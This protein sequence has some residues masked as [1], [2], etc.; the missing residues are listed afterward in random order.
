[1]LFQRRILMKAKDLIDKAVVKSPALFIPVGVVNWR[2]PTGSI[3]IDKILGGGFPGGRLTQIYGQEK[4]GKTTLL[5][6]AI[7]EGQKMGLTSVLLSLEGTY[8]KYYAKACGIDVDSNT[9]N[10][11]SSDNAE[12]GFNTIISLLM[13]SDAKIIAIDSIAA[14][15]PRANVEKKHAEKP[16][17]P[18]AVIGARSRVITDFITNA[19][20]P[21][22]R[23]DITL[24]VANQLR[25]KINTMG[26]RSPL[27]PAGGQALQYFT[28]VKVNMWKPNRSGTTTEVVVDKGKDWF[29][30]AYQACTIDIVHGK[31]INKEKEMIYLGVEAGLIKQAGSWFSYNN[32]KWHGAEDAAEVLC[33]DTAI[34]DE[35][36]NSIYESGVGIKPVTKELF[37]IMENKEENEGDA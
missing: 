28:T 36:R 11:F 5:Y 30:D 27:V 24:I 21:M 4:V 7:A 17:D 26:G 29:I 13:D 23:Q 12:A 10:V 20:I 1:M 32:Y 14:A 37:Q 18:G 33:T 9:F 2:L 16:S 19:L 25:T 31:G 35:L 6:S 3:G 34:R 8:D 15:N 22:L